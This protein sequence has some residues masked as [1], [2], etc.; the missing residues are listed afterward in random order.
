MYK[1]NTL[2]IFPPS[3]VGLDIET[4]GLDRFQCHIRAI[5]LSDGYNTWILTENFERIVPIL[6]DP[7]CIKIIHNAD[8]DLTVICNKYK[9][10]PSNIWDTLIVERLIWCGFQV[11]HKLDDVL[12]RRLSVMLDKSVR[13]TFIDYEGPLTNEQLNYLE[14]DCKYLVPL[15]KEQNKE[16]SEKGLGR[17]VALEN[18]VILPVL[19]MTLTGV[20]FNLK[21]WEGESSDNI[22]MLQEIKNTVT[23]IEH[24]IIR[25]LG[26][27]F[28]IEVEK[29]KTRSVKKVK[30]SYIVV[31]KINVE[32]INFGSP[33]QLLKVLNK[34]GI[35][36]STTGHEML[37]KLVDEHPFISL[38]LEYKKWNKM[39]SW[40][41]TKFINPDTG[42]IHPSWKQSGPDTGRFAC[43]DP[44][45]Q[46]VPRPSSEKDENGNNKYP[47]MRTL[48]TGLPGHVL[49]TADYSQQEPRILAGVSGDPAMLKAAQE[50]DIYSA[51]A[52]EIY[53]KEVGKK[54]PERQ[55][56][57]TGVLATAYGSREKGLAPKLGV[58]VDETKEFQH[59]VHAAYPVAM[60][61]GNSQVKIVK[62][63]GF[64]KTL[65]GRRRYFPEIKSVSNDQLWKYDNVCRN[66]PIQGTGA[67]ATKYALWKIYKLIN[68]GN[69]DAHIIMTIHDEI[70]VSVRKDQAEELYPKVIE[71]METAAS[72]VC[73]GVKFI[74]EGKISEI[75]EH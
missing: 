64:S 29:K 2:P 6:E 33:A 31:E 36:V 7:N 16:I 27:E 60:S 63:C 35:E 43:G 50:S 72:T 38:L 46:Q 8:F 41:W 18:H 32:E 13:E 20:G 24:D 57:K 26:Y 14:N 23:R 25:C 70:V 62:A 30:E 40:N 69:Y 11:D 58:T 54:D 47:N 73:P 48:F 44:N 3:V 66:N 21:L 28:Y 49:I 52:R 9:C 75:W 5:G 56:T 17:V 55:L 1:L 19:D 45:L 22:G 74:A 51:F 37:E 59:K 61:W 15:Y 42:R 10:K 65:T 34:L 68:E 12:A 4:T 71:A 53:K 39:S 67:D